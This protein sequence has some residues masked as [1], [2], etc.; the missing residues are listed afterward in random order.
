V[1]PKDIAQNAAFVARRDTGTQQSMPKDELLAKLPD[2]L[3]EI[4]SNLFDRALKMRQANTVSLNSLAEFRQYFRADADETSSHGG[5]A[6][7]YFA[8]EEAVKEVLQELKVTIRCIPIDQE[9]TVGKCF[10]TG[11][12]TTQRA[13]FAKAY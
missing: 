5:F 1:G 13:I 8:S 11:Q 3:A 7:C 12:E 4:Q 10:V 9:P 2:L 6:Y